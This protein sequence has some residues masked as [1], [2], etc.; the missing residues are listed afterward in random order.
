MDRRLDACCYDANNNEMMTDQNVP[1][2]LW[3]M[4][5]ALSCQQ[6]HQI[7][8]DLSHLFFLDWK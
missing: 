8:Q 6:R 7:R 1:A 3:F 5:R 2:Y 4:A